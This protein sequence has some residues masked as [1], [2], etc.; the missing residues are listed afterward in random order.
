PF[1]PDLTE[2]LAWV[3]EM[4]RLGVAL[5]NVSLGNPYATPHLIR[6]FEYPPPDGYETPEH[7]LIGVDR[8][9]RLAAQVRQAF[10]QL[11][12]VGSGYSY[13]QEFLCHAGAANVRDRR[14]SF[15]GVGRAALP[16]PDFVRQPEQT[17]RL[18]H[19]RVCRPFSYCTAL[20]RPKH[21]ELGQSAPGCP[22]FDRETSGPIWDEARQGP[23]PAAPD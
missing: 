15:V 6:P 7:P 8:H 4:A 20:M 21:K 18:D 3:G 23:P 9:F 17:G 10:P 14:I 2:P 16:Q 12:V 22:P 11:P 1:Q 19:R 13:L 5:A